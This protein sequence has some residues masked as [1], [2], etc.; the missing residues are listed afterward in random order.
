[1]INNNTENSIIASISAVIELM[2]D[3]LQKKLTV[4]MFC[5]DLFLFQKKILLSINAV[6]LFFFR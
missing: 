6:Q 2:L 3:K 4:M 1:M 5:L